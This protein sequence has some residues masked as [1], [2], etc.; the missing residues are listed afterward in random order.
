MINRILIRL[1]DDVSE[2]KKVD[3]LIDFAV[4]TFLG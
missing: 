1:Y 4:Q 3:K 2:N